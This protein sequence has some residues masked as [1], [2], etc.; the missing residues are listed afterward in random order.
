VIRRSARTLGIGLSHDTVR[1]VVMECGRVVWANEAPV[2]EEQLGAALRDLVTEARQ[3]HGARGTVAVAVGPTRAQLRRLHGLPAVRDASTLAAIVQQNAGRYFRQNGVPMIT[4]PIDEM[5]GDEGWAGAIE[6]TIVD[7]I[8]DVGRELRI[9]SIS[10]APLAALLGHAAPDSALAWH[11]GEVAMEL[12]YERYRLVESRSAPASLLTRAHGDG[13]ELAPE[14]RELGDDAL[15]YADA[16]AAA[17]GGSVNRLAVQPSGER[18]RRDARRLATA[19]AA[20]VV[21][22]SFA[23]LAPTFAAMRVQR[24]ASARLAKISNAAAPAQRV[25][26]AVADSA[27][28]L[29]RLVTFQRTAVSRTLLLA[30]LSC[31]VEEPAMLL[32]LRLE[33]SGGTL[34]ALAPTAAD[35]LEMLGKVPA[36]VSPV[37]VGSV[38]PESRPA[39]QVTPLPPGAAGAAARA[40]ERPLERVT[41]RFEWRAGV[42]PATHPA[43][44]DE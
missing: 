39:V 40:A 2:D 19:G 22:L 7:A 26:R 42:K 5:S 35:L 28:L 27:R 20:F 38:T 44:C 16:Y 43:G 34:T 17:R 37:I 9:S 25:E 15:R 33:P 12:R 29:A 18:R 10:I 11:D 41:V 13:A 3:V 24:S 23:A 14:L 8:A 36:I 30:T 31:V 21:A 6:S 4:T 32:S 1:A